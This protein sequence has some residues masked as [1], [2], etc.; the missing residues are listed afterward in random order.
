MLVLGV[1]YLRVPTLVGIGQYEL[2]ADLPASGGLYATAN[3][4]YR[5]IT[6]G[7]V[8]DVEPT[9]NGRQGDDEHRPTISR[10]R[11]DS[12]ANVHS[13]SAVG[14]QYLDL[15]S[16]GQAPAQYFCGPE[17]TDHQEHRAKRDR[18]GAGHRQPWVW[19]CCRRTRSASCSTRRRKRSVGLGP[20][21]HRL[22]DGTQAI[23]Q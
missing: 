13:V 20:A 19:R 15:V 2:T 21:L 12:S 18:P 4:T 17:Q 16:D 8:T 7:K 3:V 9:P 1:Y 6:I 23:A 11:L 10:S 22:V 5:G 14:E